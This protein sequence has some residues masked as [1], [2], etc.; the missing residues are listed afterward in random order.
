MNILGFPFK[1][2]THDCTETEM[3][4]WYW[5]GVSG[6]K[7][8]HSVYDPANCPPLP[9]AVYVAVKRLGNTRT[10][11]AVGR[12]NTVLD[13]SR[14]AEERLRLFRLG[15]DEIHVHLLA[16]SSEHADAIYQDLCAV[17]D[18]KDDQVAA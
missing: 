9:G 12:F 5:H 4:F 3:Q 13:K 14:Q 1:L 15:T 17:M 2:P 16:K 7:Y 8:I 6:R 10:A 11:V 18:A